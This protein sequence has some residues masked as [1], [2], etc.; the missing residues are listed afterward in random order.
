MPEI[1]TIKIADITEPIPGRPEFYRLTQTSFANVRLEGPA[2]IAVQSGLTI[3]DVTY[4]GE[5]PA[6]TLFVSY[7]LDPSPV[8]V[9]M[10]IADTIS[11]DTCRLAGVTIAVH[12]GHRDGLVENLNE[13]RARVEAERAAI[14]N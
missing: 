2:I 1:R 12:P 10:I 6:E 8:P 7:P 3:S 14:G 5:V 4:E 13:A 11:I 9:G